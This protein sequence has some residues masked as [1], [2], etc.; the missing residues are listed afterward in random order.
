[1]KIYETISAVALLAIAINLSIQTLRP[2]QA[3]ADEKPRTEYKVVEVVGKLDSIERNRFS[4][5]RPPGF[6]V[7]SGAEM[8]VVDY[9]K[10]SR[11]D[12]M[13]APKLLL[14]KETSGE[15]TVS[16]LFLKE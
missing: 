13:P 16:P 1:M 7:K 14:I 12:V 8:Q 5:G 15:R 4:I 9:D 6:L 11:F 10:G 2:N 3:K